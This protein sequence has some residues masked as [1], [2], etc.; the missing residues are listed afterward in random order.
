MKPD[1]SFNT[2]S[3]GKEELTLTAFMPGFNKN[4]ASFSPNATDA[5]I[6]VQIQTVAMEE[7]T[8][9]AEVPRWLINLKTHFKEEFHKEDLQP[10]DDVASLTPFQDAPGKPGINGKTKEVV[11]LGEIVTL[12]MKLTGK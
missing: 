8:Y 10:K 12:I 7:T 9:D 11:D 6:V 4:T 2:P 3:E 1:G 5:N